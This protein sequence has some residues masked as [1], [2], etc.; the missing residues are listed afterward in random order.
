MQPPQVTPVYKYVLLPGNH[1]QH[2][3]R[4]LQKRKN[5]VEVTDSQIND[6]HFIWSPLNISPQVFR[7]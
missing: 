7:H 5:W 3:K 2:I 6:A 4:A 1:H